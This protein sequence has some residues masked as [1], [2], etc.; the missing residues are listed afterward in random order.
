MPVRGEHEFLAEK[1][2]QFKSDTAA[3]NLD[4]L[5]EC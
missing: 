1:A 2:K 4:R 3:A 5:R